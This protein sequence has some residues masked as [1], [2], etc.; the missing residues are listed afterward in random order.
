MLVFLP[1]QL[2]FMAQRDLRREA[3]MM[4]ML[5]N[6]FQAPLFFH[7]NMSPFIDED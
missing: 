4:S 6:I 1:S 7:S 2:V 5:P 3:Q